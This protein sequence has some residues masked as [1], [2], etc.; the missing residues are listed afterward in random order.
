[1]ALQKDTPQPATSQPMATTVPT[2]TSQV[3]GLTAP[4]QCALCPYS[5]ALH[6]HLVLFVGGEKNT[7]YFRRRHTTFRPEAPFGTHGSLKLLSRC[8]TGAGKTTIPS[9]SAWA[10]QGHV[11]PQRLIFLGR[12][13]NRCRQVALLNETGFSTTSH[14]VAVSYGIGPSLKTHPDSVIFSTLMWGAAS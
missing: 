13:W 2:R 10:P 7:A 14:A 8:G 3:C 5:G 11:A 4:L 6:R 12:S 9:D 1:M